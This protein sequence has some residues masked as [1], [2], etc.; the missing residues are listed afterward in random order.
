[1]P[2]QLD[3]LAQQLKNIYDPLPLNKINCA[4]ALLYLQE[5]ID[6]ERDP[7]KAYFLLSEYNFIGLDHSEPEFFYILQ[8]KQTA[9]NVYSS[10]KQWQELLH[11]YSLSKYDNLRAY[12]IIET[13]DGNHLLRRN[14][15]KLYCPFQERQAYWQEHYFTVKEEKGFLA[16]NHRIPEPGRYQATVSYIKRAK[17]NTSQDEKKYNTFEFKLEVVPEIPDETSVPV[18][19]VREP[20]TVTIEELLETAKEMAQIVPGDYCYQALNEN[21]ILKVKDQEVTP[22]DKLEIKEVINIVGMVG[23]G[24]STLIKVL[25]YWMAKNHYRM[26]IV[27]DTVASVFHLV[28]YLLQFT[29]SVSPLIGQSERYRYIDQ[30][31]EPGK[32]SLDPLFSSYLTT[33]CLLDGLTTSQPEACSYG[34]EPCKK[35]QKVVGPS[36]TVS[37]RCPFFNFCPKTKMLRDCYTADIVVTTAQGLASTRV[38]ASYEMF[39]DLAMDCF[40][41]VV[42]D[43]SDRVQQTLDSHFIESVS[44][45]QFIKDATEE[46]SMFGNQDF[47]EKM[48]KPALQTYD[49]YLRLTSVYMS[50]IIHATEVDLGNW[51][52]VQPN[53]TFSSLSLLNDL[54]DSDE[55]PREI[56]NQI[57]ALIMPLQTP[58]PLLLRMTRNSLGGVESEL[59]SESFIYDFNEWRRSNI[60]CY[61]L[62]NSDEELAV[63]N[64]RLKLILKLI[65]FDQYLKDLADA[66]EDAKYEKDSPLYNFMRS[67]FTQQ[68]RI[69]P[70]ALTGNLLGI[71][72]NDK[73]D[74]ILYKQFAFGRSLMKDLPYLRLNENGE[75]MGPHVFMLSGSSWAEG[76]LTYHVNRSV[77]YI[78]D[79]P[80]EKKTFLANTQF[81]FLD[82]QIRVSGTG[83]KRTTN[84]KALVDQTIFNVINAYNSNTGKMLMVTNSYA[85]GETLQDALEQALRSHD[86][87]AKS[88]RMISDKDKEES[89]YT[90]R[91]SEIHKFA[92]SDADIL[93]APAMAIERGHNIVDEEGHSAINHLFFMVR[94]MS[95]PDSLKYMAS[96]VNGIVEATCKYHKGDSV[97]THCTNVRRMAVKEW[98]IMNNSRHLRLADLSPVERK[99]IVASLFI[100]ILQTFGRMARISDP[101]KPAPHVYFVDGA[102]KASSNKKNVFDCLNEFGN[103]LDFMMNGQDQA[104]AQALYGPFYDAFNRT[105]RRK[106]ES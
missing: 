49:N 39:L 53:T 83:A 10:K 21:T 37:K 71:Q 91:R 92:F 85:E 104:I 5:K 40:D 78:L 84:L 51:D 24:K 46:I 35:V 95:R 67:R 44:F 65:Q 56:Y 30:L 106:G 76:A 103:Y 9:L 88:L 19:G 87:P 105:L 69:L 31:Y 63:Q 60:S 50:K 97:I 73:K 66:Y 99:D 18:K 16:Y 62:A 54:Y 68:Q 23:S 36:Y 75:P 32:M 93:I 22:T 61:P 59:D 43:E 6:P 8:A 80:E 20:I 74:L 38:G 96:K 94:P 79:I 89:T 25:A 42:F 64:N 13:D 70:S 58:S 72:I 41:L 28:K 47:S 86:C 45:N 102:F 98:N 77:D 1:M 29:S 48:E 52:K 33:T 81:H 55:I 14:P 4:E 2:K 90:I 15:D 11:E 26:V 82:T 57:L 101:S 7:Y 100:I 34:D 3:A 17:D 27:T 12:R